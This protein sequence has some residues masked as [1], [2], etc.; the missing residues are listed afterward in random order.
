MKKLKDYTKN[1]SI[2]K[3]NMEKNMLTK[4]KKNSEKS[5]LIFT[6]YKLKKETKKAMILT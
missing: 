4:L 1:L 2:G 6:N 5:F 3:T